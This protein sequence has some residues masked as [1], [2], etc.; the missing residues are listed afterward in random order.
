MDQLTHLSLHNTVIA[1]ETFDIASIRSVVERIEG[2]G[3]KVNGRH[4][5][6]ARIA[7]IQQR[8][9]ILLT[10]LHF[11]F[12]IAWL[13]RPVLR[14]H[15]AL[16]HATPAQQELIE[17]CLRS[18]KKCL[19][20]FIALQSMCTF[21]SRSWAVIHNGLSSALLLALLGET[22]RDEAAKRL[23]DD[24]L[25]VFSEIPVQEANNQLCNLSTPHL[26]A[27]E[28]LRRIR[29][30]QEAFPSLRQAEVMTEA[31]TA[32]PSE[33]DLGLPTN[34]ASVHYMH[35]SCSIQANKPRLPTTTFPGNFPMM[36]DTQAAMGEMYDATSGTNWNA[37]GYSLLD[38]F[39]SIIW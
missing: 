32:M 36:S 9:E 16:S 29:R 18:L 14:D 12:V 2:F 27:I 24:L 7:N 17:I 19:E 11:Q 1:S 22:A 20:S 3:F 4:I 26:R 34:N 38:T 37:D 28:I 25:E 31:N 10:D 33:H 13:C 23:L 21:A 6:S 30:E 39:D 5:Q 15:T 8:C 35:P